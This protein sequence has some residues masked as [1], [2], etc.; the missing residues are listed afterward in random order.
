MTKPQHEAGS[1]AK[2]SKTKTKTKAASA[3]RAKSKS[4]KTKST[5][6]AAAE[7]ASQLT[8]A[9]R[10]FIDATIA[11]GEAVQLGADGEMPPGAT[12]EVIEQPTGEQIVR[13]KRFSAA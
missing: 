8:D 3:G 12:H 1:G 9:E 5:K 10:A 7:P 11:R 2:A 4:T 6:P 13:R